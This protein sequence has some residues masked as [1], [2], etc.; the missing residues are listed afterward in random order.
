VAI[1]RHHLVDV[2]LSTQRPALFEPMKGT[3]VARE[4]LLLTT[5]SAHN[6]RTHKPVFFWLIALSYKL[7]GVPNG[8][9][10]SRRASCALLVCFPCGA[11]AVGG[12]LGVTLV[13]SAE[14]YLFAHRDF[15]IL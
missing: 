6:F 3:L 13:T 5:G 4:I 8:R 12:S 11:G 15:D 9:V 14:F 1:V 7:F 10:P 2:I